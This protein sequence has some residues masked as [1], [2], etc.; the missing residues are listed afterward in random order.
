MAHGGDEPLPQ[1]LLEVLL[2]GGTRK[3]CQGR[4]VRCRH[5]PRQRPLREAL[6]G[7][8][9]PRPAS[10][11]HSPKMAW[12]GFTRLAMTQKPRIV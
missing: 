4:H 2:A 11:S 9:T 7:R 1:A 3:S 5:R 12:A 6:R 10:G 8:E